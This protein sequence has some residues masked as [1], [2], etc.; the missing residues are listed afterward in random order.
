[1]VQPTYAPSAQTA[2]KGDWLAAYLSDVLLYV[3]SLSLFSVFI[4]MAIFWADL[5]KGVS[6][7]QQGTVQNSVV[8][9]NKI[10]KT[11]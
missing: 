5:I 7:V 10:Y 8:Q 11:V 2:F 4:L 9:F 1:M 6:V 3:G